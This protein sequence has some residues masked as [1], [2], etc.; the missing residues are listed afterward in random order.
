[1]RKILAIVIASVTLCGCGE[2]SYVP[3]EEPPSE[4]QIYRSNGLYRLNYQGSGLI[5]G[6]GY[7]SRQQ[8]VEAAWLL[9]RHVNFK[10]III[11][12]S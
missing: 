5:L 3:Y 8:A 4:W 11:P 12:Q 2:I 10:I 6:V 7:E 1:M 9:K